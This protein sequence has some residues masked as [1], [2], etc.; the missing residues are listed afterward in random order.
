MD[1]FSAAKNVTVM[2]NSVYGKDRGTDEKPEEESSKA[3]LHKSRPKAQHLDHIVKAPS[4]PVQ[5]SMDEKALNG[6]NRVAADGIVSKEE[7]ETLVRLV[8]VC[9]VGTWNIAELK[10][11]SVILTT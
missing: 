6:T 7:C 2:Y 5:I 9:V 1:F 11:Y 10:R 8:Q 3:K 4:D